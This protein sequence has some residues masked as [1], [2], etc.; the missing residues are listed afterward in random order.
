[1]AV[2]AGTQIVEQKLRK[3]KHLEGRDVT[4]KRRKSPGVGQAQKVTKPGHK[5]LPKPLLTQHSLQKDS[6]G[7]RKGLVL[8]CWGLN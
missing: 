1:M 3:N 8:W 6:G 4:E 2:P 5:D 7:D